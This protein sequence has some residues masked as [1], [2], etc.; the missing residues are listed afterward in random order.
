MVNTNELHNYY[1]S[2]AHELG[3]DKEK[4]TQK[5][6]SLEFCFNDN[7]YDILQCNDLMKAFFGDEAAMDRLDRSREPV[8]PE[9]IK[10]HLINTDLNE[11]QL[12]AV[13]MALSN[14]V[15]M[16]QG[17]PGTGKTEVILN[18]LSCIKHLYPKR[19]VAVLSTN[20]EA[21]NNIHEKIATS[22]K[23]SSLSDSIIRLGCGAQRK[24]TYEDREDQ[25]NCF[26]IAA[27]KEY[28]TYYADQNFTDDFP[29]FTSTIH[30][31]KKLYRDTEKGMKMQYDYVIVDE[32]SQASVMLGIVAMS[33]AKR[34][35]LIGDTEQLPPIINRD[36][37][38]SINSEYEGKIDPIYMEQDEKSFLDVCNKVFE[39]LPNTKV[40]LK[41]HYR[42]HPSIIG[43]NNQYVYNNELVI[44]EAKE[45]AIRVVWYEGDYFETKH[46]PDD[47]KKTVH[48]NWRQIRI[49]LEEEWP[50]I[51]E[52]IL[53]NENYSVG[54]MA[55]YRSIL[56]TLKDKLKEKNQS[57]QDII[58]D[59]E[60]VDENNTEETE[61]ALLEQ[62]YSVLTIHKSQGKGFNCVVFLSS[63][64][65]SYYHKWPW[66]QRKRMMNVM[67][68]RAKEELCIITSSQWL[69]Q[70]FQNDNAN[71][72]ISLKKK[73]NSEEEKD[74]LFLFKLLDYVYRDCLKLN[75]DKYHGFY[76]SK[77]T[78]IFDEVPYY[79]E[80]Y[81]TSKSAGTGVSAPAYCMKSAL[82]ERYKNKYDILPE[83]PLRLLFDECSE[84]KLQLDFVICD[85]DRVLVAV[86]VDGAYHRVDE[87][88]EKSDRRKGDIMSRHKEIGFIRVKTDGSEPDNIM[89][90]IDTEIGKALSGPKAILIDRKEYDMKENRKQ[91]VEKL[92]ETIAGCFNNFSNF[93]S[94]NKDNETILV[95][96]IPNYCKLETIKMI[97]YSNDNTENYYICRYGTAYA[98]EY[99]LM[100][101]MILCDKWALSQEHSCYPF[102]DPSVLCLG[103]GAMFGLWGIKYAIAS[104]AE[105]EI[106]NIK[107]DSFCGFDFVDWPVKID[108]DK[109]K[110]DRFIEGDITG[111]QKESCFGEGK[112]IKQ[113][114]IMFSKILNEL[115]EAEVD[116]L[117]ALIEQTSFP[118]DEYYICFSHNYSSVVAKENCDKKGLFISE[119]IA[120]TIKEQV[121]KSHPDA[122]LYYSGDIS[123][124]NNVLF[125]ENYSA[126]TQD[127]VVSFIPKQRDNGIKSLAYYFKDN[128]N[129][130]CKKS[131]ADYEPDF[132][133]NNDMENLFYRISNRDIHH[134][135]VKYPAKNIAFQIVK[136]KVMAN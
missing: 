136:I 116:K 2:L 51:K 35:V 49:F 3:F 87:N 64:D 19:T 14:N 96:T 67:T 133:I 122:G 91:L 110:P 127:I 82:E 90:M 44:Q 59:I 66:S 9:K 58:G 123:G 103:C 18:I 94:N 34:I 80:K 114:V 71:H 40:M 8:L 106:G 10:K 62:S 55:P 11:S 130:K 124:K 52:K 22:D 13:R 24:D 5:G 41:T 53:Q 29:F 6:Y 93:Y 15:T 21:L 97:D 132:I 12:E 129:E 108:G 128:D 83:V 89:E 39:K 47:E 95:K 65:C 117:I 81:H 38:D 126:I 77:I 121:Q 73:D 43:F 17:P 63:E 119:K 4:Q 120:A 109:M 56:N 23:Y 74:N 57:E 84:T 112:E 72:T 98:F 76:K 26:E 68:S 111:A 88:Q 30:S 50:I 25:R 86:E 37:V 131:F 113:N 79:R 107:F 99:A 33:C 1:Q 125:D 45:L 42:C 92:Q 75:C 102:I 134:N 135:V 100:Y 85:G 36:V 104:L 31:A 48:T 61:T 70:G 69:P 28:Q 101:K 27:N 46:L 115:S 20:N 54:I 16:I 105:K 118:G 32:C 60:L 78:S 7:N